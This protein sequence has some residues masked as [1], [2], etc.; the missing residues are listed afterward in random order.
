MDREDKVK[1][2]QAVVDDT[3]VEIP[4]VDMISFVETNP[5]MLDT[6]QYA[7]SLRSTA[8]RLESEETTAEEVAE[9]IGELIGLTAKLYMRLKTPRSR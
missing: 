7:T 8:R 3:L 2:S 6:T 1:N 5:V 9:V 4:L